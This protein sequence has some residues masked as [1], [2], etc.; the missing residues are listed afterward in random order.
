MWARF[1][2]LDRIRFIRDILDFNFFS[3]DNVVPI[4]DIIKPYKSDLIH[5]LFL[6]HNL[7]IWLYLVSV[8]HCAL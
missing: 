8:M 2:I 6:M 7:Q 5:E 1:Q 3:L 4:R